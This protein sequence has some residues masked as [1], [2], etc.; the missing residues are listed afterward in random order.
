VSDSPLYANLSVPGSGSTS[1][2]GRPPQR[3][4]AAES[5]MVV[6]KAHVTVAVEAMG[7]FV[8]D[9]AWAAEPV[10]A[11]LQEAYVEAHYRQAANV[12]NQLQQARERRS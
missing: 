2:P 6:A 8:T 12:A 7:Q 11:L 4:L 9:L 1:E 10:I 3:D 5:G